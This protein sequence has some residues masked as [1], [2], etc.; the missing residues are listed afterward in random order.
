V[1]ALT[2]LE[3]G[4]AGHWRKVRLVVLQRDRRRCYW[5]GGYATQVDHLQPRALGGARYDLANLVAA[6]ATCNLRRGGRLGAARSRWSRRPPPNRTRQ[7][8]PGAI[9]L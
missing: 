3:K 8:W 4:L 2:T 1:A 7:V 5:C 9:T 6:C